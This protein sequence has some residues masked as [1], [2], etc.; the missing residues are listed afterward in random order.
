[1]NSQQMTFVSDPHHVKT[2]MVQSSHQG[3][4][5]NRLDLFSQ[6]NQGGNP[7]QIPV[8]KTQHQNSSN[9]L[10]VKNQSTI[11]QKF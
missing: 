4:H 1:M 2:V 7:N 10:G 6:Q 3:P 11:N 9:T 5:Q 8:S